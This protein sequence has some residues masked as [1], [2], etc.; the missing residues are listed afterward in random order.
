MI[1]HLIPIALAL[2]F[3]T[4]SYCQSNVI[5]E[6]QKICPVNL[7]DSIKVLN[8]L[9]TCAQASRPHQP[10]SDTSGCIAYSYLPAQKNPI[11]IG[12]VGF[13]HININISRDKRI[14]S[15]LYLKTYITT[16]TVFN[17][18]GNEERL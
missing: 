13:T 10:Y 11:T 5:P 14:R 8:D 6:L 15:V 7:G 17:G 12:D 9:V 18:T 4:C 2:L 3:C 16:D 1:K